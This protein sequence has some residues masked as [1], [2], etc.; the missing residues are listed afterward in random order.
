MKLVQ[1]SLD[2]SPGVIALGDGGQFAARWPAEPSVIATASVFHDLGNL[3]Q[4]AASVINI[5]GRT[6]E[7]PA[8]HAGPLLDRAR[9][10]LEHAGTLVR[11]NVR[12]TRNRAFADEPTDV[13]ACLRE[14]AELVE[15]TEET[16]LALVLEI[17]PDIPDV[18]CDGVGLRRAV[19][20]L[21]FNA[22]DAIDGNGVVVIKARSILD[23]RTGIV[24][25]IEI[26]DNGI[27]MTRDVIAH[28][29]D[30]FFTT[31]SDGL[32][33]IGLAMVANFV[34][35]AGGDVALSSEEGFGTAVTMRLPTNA[36]AV[37]ARTP[38]SV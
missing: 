2:H 6:P 1:S 17:E 29:F 34:R 27:G 11:E 22:R 13:A 35:D 12:Q 18:R 28:A 3:I 15:A 5:I 23:D 36:Q 16:G 32:G 7:M 9:T 20:N 31:K 14:A 38:L 30:P 33:G 10:S 19:L 4:I 24:V 26:V 21:I 25:E 8:I 37:A